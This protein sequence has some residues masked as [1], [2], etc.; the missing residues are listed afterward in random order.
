MYTRPRVVTKQV[1]D[2]T[3]K[4]LSPVQS[5]EGGVIK[6]GVEY[7]VIDNSKEL[8]KYTSYDFS[9]ENILALGAI[10]AL[11]PVVMMNMSDMTFADKF[12]DMNVSK[13]A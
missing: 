7:K 13:P 10:D 11:K 5:V 4:V 2:P 6:R 1:Y 12:Q 8:S 9:L 3:Q